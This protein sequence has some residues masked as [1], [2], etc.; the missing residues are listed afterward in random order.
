MTMADCG[1]P[2]NT[3]IL[4]AK[5]AAF[6]TLNLPATLGTGN[7]Q[8]EVLRAGHFELGRDDPHGRHD[9]GQGAGGA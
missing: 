2:A 4:L 5:K 7:R 3:P 1:W 6:G 9:F 8:E